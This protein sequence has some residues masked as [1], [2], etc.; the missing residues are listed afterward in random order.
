[1][2]KN[3]V[4]QEKLQD[5]KPEWSGLTFCPEPASRREWR[6]PRGLQIRAEWK[7]SNRDIKEEERG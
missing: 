3:D 7:E 4:W 2:K 1:M 5:K 6:L